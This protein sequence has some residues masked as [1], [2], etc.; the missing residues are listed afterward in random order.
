MELPVSTAELDEL[1]QV[2]LDTLAQQGQTHKRGDDTVQEI[3]F[4]KRSVT[5]DG[6][7]LILE[8]D[9][10]RL[11]YRV[12]VAD[13]TAKEMLHQLSAAL[14]Y[15][16]RVANGTGVTYIVHLRQGA[17][18]PELPDCVD[19][20]DVLPRHP[21]TPF[22]FPV[23]EGRRG[24][25]WSS[26][27]GH[28][29]VGGETGSGKTTWLLS[30]LLT[31]TLTTPPSELQLLIIDPKVV[32]FLPF[33]DSPHLALPIASDVAAATAVI[34]WSLEQIA[35]RQQLF[36][37]YCA[38]DLTGYNALA[39]ER[40][41]RILVVIDEVTDLAL[42]AGMNSALYRGLKSLSSKA[43]AFGLSLILATQH[44]KAEVLNTLIRENMGARIAFRVVSAQHS[45]TILDKAGAEDLPR[46][47][48][49]MVARLDGGDLQELQ[50]YRIS[51]EVLL[52]L[53]KP[54]APIDLLGRE[55]RALLRY[56]VEHLDGSFPEEELLRA[57]RMRRGPFRELK[58]RLERAGY[59]Q[60]GKNNALQVNRETAF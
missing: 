19:L 57:F 60:R 15:R 9:T 45:R 29:L 55:A 46:T 8:V 6:S 32:D 25:V 34:D 13:L 1:S 3:V 50:G 51:E 53:R 2:A 49:R 10:R 43:R 16:V 52:S 21:R 54:V 36:A 58:D 41:P 35:A 11:P 12:R 37:R 56:A 22:T 30:T 31:L 39:A 20:A 26:L 4:R 42:L 38:R 44:P 27:G 28:F 48:G 14:H 24:T 47:P 5:R 40:L 23:G 33:G 7:L 17:P 18:R 59:L